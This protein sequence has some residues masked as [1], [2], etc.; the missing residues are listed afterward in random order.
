MNTFAV[1]NVL[2]MKPF[3]SMELACQ[4]AHFLT[5]TE[6]NGA[7]ISVTI[8]V[9]QPIIFIGTA[10]ALLVVNIHFMVLPETVCYTVSILDLSAFIYTI[11]ELAMNP[12]NSLWSKE[13]N[14]D[15][16]SVIS[17]VQPVIVS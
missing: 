6:E 1:I 4:P 14:L 3:T 12:V 9:L 2:K 13:M 15:I 8:L 7:E 10:L 17:L 5:N 11:T 16:F